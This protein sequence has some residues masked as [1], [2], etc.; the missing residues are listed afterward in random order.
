MNNL[1]DMFCNFNYTKTNDDKC[2]KKGFHKH[3]QGYN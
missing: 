2:N 3:I 1:E